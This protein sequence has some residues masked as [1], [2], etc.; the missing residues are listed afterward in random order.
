MVG[1]CSAEYFNQH[2]AKL[3]TVLTHQV[4]GKLHSMNQMS[5]VLACQVLKLLV[6]RKVHNANCK[7][8]MYVPIYI[9]RLCRKLL[10]SFRSILLSGYAKTDHSGSQ[11]PRREQASDPGVPEDSS[12]IGADGQPF[13]WCLAGDPVVSGNPVA[14]VPGVLRGR[15]S[16]PSG[17]IHLEPDIGGASCAC[18][19][20]ATCKMFRCLAKV[21]LHPLGQKVSHQFR[22]I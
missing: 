8:G 7:Y 13:Q 22:K 1:Q 11:F 20:R 5:A 6:H 4:I 3:V 9:A 16:H 12:V 10:Q 2:G 17:E 21:G 18:S 19:R 15:H 14:Q